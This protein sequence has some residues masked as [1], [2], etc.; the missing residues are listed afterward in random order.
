MS[1]IEEAVFSRLSSFAGLTALVAARIYPVVLPQNPTYPA[2]TYQRISS[3]RAPAMGTDT[4]LIATR[5]QLSTWSSGYAA[6]KAVKEQLRLA[7][8]RW[9]GTV[10]GIVIQ[11]TFI[12]GEVDLYETAVPVWHLPL[13]V[14]IHHVEP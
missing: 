14:R 12:E 2:V 10:L 5:F 1:Q 8:E 11:D 3:V 13:D 9:R 6:A 7:T 4:G